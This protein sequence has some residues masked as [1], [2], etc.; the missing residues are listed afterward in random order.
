MA[1]A[2]G[3]EPRSPESE[4]GILPMYEAPIWWAR[5]VSIQLPPKRTDLQSAAVADLLLTRRWYSQRDLNPYYRLE[6]PA[7]YQLEDGSIWRCG[8]DSNRRITALQAAPLNHLG[9]T[10]YFGWDGWNRTSV[11]GV[12]TLCLSHS[13]TPQYWYSPPGS[14]RSLPT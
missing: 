10:S 12:K 1:G 6:R 14:N 4:S 3:I 9:T 8:P 2:R 13:A 7:S 5:L 11:A